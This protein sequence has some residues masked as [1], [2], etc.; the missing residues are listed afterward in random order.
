MQL[1]LL[2]RVCD[3][4]ARLKWISMQARLGADVDDGRR[5]NCVEA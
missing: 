4:Q 5:N 1:M 3:R 2:L